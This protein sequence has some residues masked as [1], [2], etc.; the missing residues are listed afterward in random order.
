M[1]QFDR[2]TEEAKKAL[3]VAEQE[4]K[5]EGVGYIGTEHIL[6]GILQ[7]TSTLGYAVLNSYGVSLKNVRLVIQQ[8]SQNRAPD[9]AASNKFMKVELSDF[10][11]KAIEEAVLSAS[12]F[13]HNYIGTEHLL[14]GLM[15]QKGT[16]ATVI[17]ENMKIN[18]DEVR[19]KLSEVFQQSD[20]YKSAMQ[21]NFFNPLE[22]MLSSLNGVIFSINPNMQ[23]MKD[24]FKH[25]EGETPENQSKTPALDYFTIDLTA[26]ARNG[27]L[28]PVIGRAKEVERMINI[29]NRKTKNNPVLIGEPG[30]GK[31][32]IVE[33]LAQKIAK[34]E[35]P[36][37]LMDKKVLALDMASMIAGTKYRG[38]FESRMKQVID[39]AVKA[40]N[41]VILFVDEMHTLIGAGSAEG[42]LDAAN[43]LKPA[44]GRGKI[45]LI[46]ATTTKEY[47]KHIEK[48]SALER[49][50]QPIFVD[51]P[52]ESDAVE[53]LKG[54]RTTF[55]EYHNLVITDDAVEAAV[56]LAKRYIN[57]RYLPDKAIDVLDEAMALKSVRGYD[58][59]MKEIRKA[60]EKL[61]SLVK[62]KEAAVA[63]Q[64]YDKAAKLR[65]EEL[66]MQEKLKTLKA[67]KNFPRELRMKVTSEDIATVIATTTGVPVS[68][69]VKDDVTALKNVEKRLSQYIIGQEE[70]ISSISKAIRRNRAGISNPNRPIG[71]FLFLG[72]SGVGKTELV[73]VLAK[74]VFG[75]EDALIKIDMS[76]FMERHNVSRLLGA[77]P[78]YVGYDE[79]G[80]LTEMVHK[81][82]Y[83]V[84]LFDEIEK[85]H[86]EVFNILLQVLEDG[87]ITDSKGRKVDF[88]NTI[89]VMTS[90]EGSGRF[91]DKAM[92]I[93]FD[94]SEE[95]LKKEEKEFDQVKED[96]LKELHDLFRPEFLNRID[97]VVV[98]RPLTKNDIKQIVE[99]EITRLQERLS[100]KKISI[101]IDK[102]AI[103]VLTQRS[104][105][106]EH[107][108]RAVRKI[109]QE[110]VE[111]TL[112]EK[113]MDMELHEGDTI[114][115][116][117]AIGKK[118]QLLFQKTV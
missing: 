67:K 32:A 64:D 91:T 45:Q 54:L 86:P 71:S 9:G 79:G 104:Y 105:N 56:R 16:A 110:M 82:P 19:I 5:N 31:T 80:Q 112:T 8:S 98:F 53:I 13:H 34:E 27:K 52:T 43:I 7:Q 88:R 95:D 28:D 6:L 50:L 21:Q 108:A 17:L 84:V 116:S 68:R 113:I 44:L 61:A 15:M 23:D 2:F 81:K 89:I 102:K 48:D 90:N 39:E 114:K 11:K 14:M 73:K 41:E 87:Y 26:E 62:E 93:G 97:K 22:K 47:R 49:R 63:A 29:L 111:D 33:G 3:M 92:K 66:K 51:E 1:G 59:D 69:L 83:S 57:D 100:L 12:Q 70:A 38:E 24:S 94:L 10:A 36:T 117:L 115:I 78:G 65:E 74:E 46:G 99:L 30:V 76:E 55:E 42:S 20:Q 72:P 58:G 18:P 25:K 4:A 103:D 40:E 101:S 77:T 75:R 107:G 35:V 85:A 118:D 37:A 106:P 109:V 60:K 96:V